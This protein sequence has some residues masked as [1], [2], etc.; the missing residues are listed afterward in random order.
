M[1]G[2]HPLARYISQHWR[3]L[4]PLDTSWGN[5]T[6]ACLS[7]AESL[8]ARRIH[9]YG[10]DFSYPKG[11]VYARGTY[12]YPF[13]E[14]KQNRLESLESL[15]SAFLYR[16]LFIP[17]EDVVSHNENRYYETI[18]LRSYRKSFEKKASAMNADVFPKPGMGAAIQINKAGS[19]QENG[20]AAIISPFAPDKARM[21]VDEF[22]EQYKKSIS[23]LP[24]FSTRPGIWLQKLD[25]AERQVLSTLLPQAAAIKRRYPELNTSKVIEVTKQYCVS[26]ID[27]VNRK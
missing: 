11:K 9:V 7:L 13:F 4:P 19:R 3:P 25:P 5:V 2:G 18:P 26:Q 1:S 6:Y 16:S 27:K 14:K 12:I 23:S 10:A 8:G 21:S 15:F 24:I 22:I 20:D 17:L